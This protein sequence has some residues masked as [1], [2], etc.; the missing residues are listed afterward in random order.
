MTAVSIVVPTRN[1]VAALGRCLDAVATQKGLDSFEVLVVDDGGG[2]ADRVRELVATRPVAR[3]VRIDGAGPAA[4]RNAGAQAAVGGVVCFT[5]DDCEP[6]PDW[7]ARLVQRLDRGADAVGGRTVN[8]RPGD[9]FI[10]ASELIT[11]HLQASTKLRLPGRVF[12]PSNNLA[13]RRSLVLE[14]PFDERYATA[15][16]EDRAWCARVATAG[17]ALVLEPR[18]VVAHHPKLGLRGFWRQHVR[19][20]RG[21]YRFARSKPGADW[22]EPPSFYLSLV[23]AGLAK[24]PGCGSL[25][26]LSQLATGAGFAREALVGHR[27]VHRREASAQLLVRLHVEP[28]GKEDELAPGDQE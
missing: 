7:A 21:A 25:I 11:Q 8:G 28:H 20:G 13:C 27:L 24:G 12:I 5:D 2:D 10:E 4:A 9:P 19:Y 22:Q 14:H 15:A 6:A 17:A 26:L 18:A 3:L 1:R 16:A 23:R